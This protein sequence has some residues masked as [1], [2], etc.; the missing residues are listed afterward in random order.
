MFLTRFSLRPCPSGRPAAGN[1]GTHAQRV[2]CFMVKADN[3]LDWANLACKRQEG[4]TYCGMA[5]GSI[6]RDATLMCIRE[7]YRSEAEDCA[8]STEINH[9]PQP[10]HFFSTRKELS[11]LSIA[12]S[13]AYTQCFRES[14]VMLKRRRAAC[15]AQL[16][17]FP[18]VEI[19]APAWQ[20]VHRP[21]QPSSRIEEA[22]QNQSVTCDVVLSG[23]YR[24]DIE[25]LRRTYEELR[26]SGCRVLS[27]TR[28]EPSRETDGFV[29]M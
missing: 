10:P 2:G 13:M 17:M 19:I 1:N 9:F 28:I 3:W 15:G 8:K 27:P 14:S 11:G 6:T 18:R 29:F 16:A 24:R 20:H 22:P 12:T 23:S 21:P 25:G 4:Y 26:D 7:K 5:P